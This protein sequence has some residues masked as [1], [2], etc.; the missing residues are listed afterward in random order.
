MLWY[1]AGI[2]L[3]IFLNWLVPKYFRTHICYLADCS[4]GWP[5]TTLANA[6]SMG[7]RWGHYSFPWIAL[8]T[9]DINLM[10]LSVKMGGMKYYFFN[11]WLTRTGIESRSTGKLAK[12]LFWLQHIFIIVD[13]RNELLPLIIYVCI[14]FFFLFKLWWAWFKNN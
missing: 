4:W 8:S 2:G 10:M 1:P 5:K 13:S 6:T 7:C 3:Y 11:L 14:L 9:Q 12:V